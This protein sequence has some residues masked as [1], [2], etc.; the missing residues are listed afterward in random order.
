[1]RVDVYKAVSGATSG[2]PEE[3]KHFSLHAISL[4][5]TKV[6]D[7]LIDPK[8]V[9]SWLITTLGAPAAFVGFL[10]P[11]RE[12]GALAPQLL[13]APFIRAAKIRKWYW[14]AGSIGQGLCV[15]GIAATAFTMS[16]AAAGWVILV[17]LAIFSVCRSICSV[18]HKDVLGKT[19]K[20]ST[21]GAATGIA[22]SLAAIGTLL[23]G[24]LLAF[25]IIPR[26]V[27]ALAVVI[28][29]AGFVWVVAGLLFMQIRENE[30]QVEGIRR[31]SVSELIAPLRDDPQLRRFITARAL[32]IPTA[33][34][35]PFLIAMATVESGGAGALGPFILA[36]ALASIL[37]GYVWGR[38]SDRSSRL[39]FVAGGGLAAGV[40]G[41]AALI[42][43]GATPRLWV[44]TGLLFAAQIGYEGV[45]TARKI[46]LVDMAEEDKRAVYTALSNT[47]IGFLLIAGG[48]LGII[49]QAA[50][51][52]AALGVSSVL[53]AAGT[54]V[55]FGLD[56]VQSR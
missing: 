43:T 54:A 15:G 27:T 34:A 12:A 8:I 56:E 41:I 20:K 32:L 18:S 21:R 48:A 16:G 55:A 14:T 2:T 35:P 45:R 37:S 44:V 33:L 53:C 40:L 23:F 6:A 51:I 42:A 5:L 52:W 36:S 31:F 30:S 29:I 50:G 39:T 11:I 28:C 7:G 19:V 25:G 13:I 47:L 10:V 22:G 9:L 24:A 49:A 1:M 3:R 26:T 17:L 4:T 38:V 46:H